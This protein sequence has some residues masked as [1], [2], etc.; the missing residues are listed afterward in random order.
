MA[1]PAP[2]TYLDL[3]LSSGAIEVALVAHVFDVAHD[4]KVEPPERFLNAATTTAYAQAIVALL[5]PRLRIEADGRAL[6]PSWSAPEVLADRNSLRLHASYRL[7][8]PPAA[9][10]VNALMFPYDPVHQTFITVY[11]RDA[12]T[13]QAILDRDHTRFG[14][15]TRTPAGLIASTRTFV[16]AG[17]RWAL[18]GWDH[19]IFLTGLLLLGGSLRRVLVLVASFTLA[20]GAALTL[21]AFHLISPS[22]RIV[23]PAIALSIVFVGIDNLLVQGGR[24]VRVW[25]ALG[26]GTIHGFG[27]ADALRALELSSGAPGWGLIAFLLGVELGQLLV[28]AAVAFVVMKIGSRSEAAGRRFAFAVS[29]VVIAAG[30]LA[31][32]KRAFFPGG[33]S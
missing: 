21:A 17:L 27:F 31:F 15:F 10:A 7:D 22:T 9:V 1:H 19:L 6:T 13:T 18:A 3:R 16:S 24:D 2:F 5:E 20:S 25:I 29:L 28:A 30:T 32:I 14:Y 23:E 33:T 11:E 8:A 4:L 12:L 26:F